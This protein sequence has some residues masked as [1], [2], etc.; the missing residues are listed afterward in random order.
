M[1]AHGRDA[2]VSTTGDL[3]E[4]ALTPSSAPAAASTATIARKDEHLAIN[5]HEHVQAKG[6]DSGFERYRFLHHALPDLDFDAVDTATSIFGRPLRAPI[7]MSCMTG[8]TPR[9]AHINAV[10]AQACA[11]LGLAM[12][13]GSGRVLLEHPERI[14]SFAVRP[15]APHAL[16]FAN[17]GA[18]Q[19]N[20]GV[21]VDACRRLLDML[22]ADALVLHL[23]P[24][25]EALQPEGDTT[26]AGLLPRI[27]ALCRHLEQPVVV[28]EV[29]WGL[30][31]DVVRALFDAGVRAV[32]VAGA[33]GTS[34]SE[35][36]RHRTSSPW[37]R[38]VAAA[39]VGWGIPTAD[40]LRSARRDAPADGLVFASGGIRT[41]I[42]V[43]K[44]LALGADL[45]GLAGPFLH[46]ADA[47]V[48]HAVDFGRSL[49]STLR[50]AMFCVDAGHLTDLRGT[51]RLLDTAPS[52]MVA[53]QLTVQTT[54]DQ[55]IV[56]ITESVQAIVNSTGVRTGQVQI[57]AR[58]T[59]V[60]IRINEYEPGLVTD[61]AAFL[62]RLAPTGGYA[63]DN[64]SAR[65]DV[66]PN[67]PLNG[68]AHCR[69]LLLASSETV[70]FAAGRLMLGT[71]QRILLL[72]LCSS[73]IRTL[74][75]QV[76]GR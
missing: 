4:E 21:S 58:H 24:L 63:H 6:I 11:E 3:R 35:V 27:A 25:Q 38:E 60:A 18:V 57:F 43:A 26:F 69:Q 59:T 75:I 40:A 50:T 72:E 10:L 67:E 13:L 15:Y 1:H 31:P 46:A 54:E 5:L 41:G 22:T 49:I 52:R 12:G 42:D 53:E 68:H 19:L 73:R 17:L 16:L 34:W 7:L 61:F 8:G 14:D 37:Q 2:G 48:G 64:L 55:R 33:G 44:A 51:P 28:K 39:F 56:D 36:E 62:E 32:D 70:P 45:V 74:T 65:P 20:R 47:G 29:G 76:I 23:N 30:A 71:W 9:A 66:G